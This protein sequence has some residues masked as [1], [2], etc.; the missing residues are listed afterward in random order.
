MKRAV[1][2]EKGGGG[3]VGTRVGAGRQC[4]GAQRGGG[5]PGNRPPPPPGRAAPRAPPGRAPPPGGPAPAAGGV[6]EL[7][8]A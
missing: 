8:E 1:R 5:G 3:C 6:G 2:T 4:Q 7:L